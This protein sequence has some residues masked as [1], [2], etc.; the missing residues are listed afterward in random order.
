MLLYVIIFGILGIFF[1]PFWILA[2]LFLL[3]ALFGDIGKLLIMIISIPFKI[4]GIL[5]GSSE[6]EK[7]V[8]KQ[9]IIEK[10]NS[11]NAEQLSK[12]S[13]LL[14]KDLISEE[15]FQAEKTKILNP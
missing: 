2:I 14:E 10:N 7:V 3:G 15:E 9:I 6:E 5:F 4:L 12:L 11:S 8:E 13:E 1:S